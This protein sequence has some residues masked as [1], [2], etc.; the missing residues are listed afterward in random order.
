MANPL[1]DASGW[2]KIIRT[3]SEIFPAKKK[4]SGFRKIVTLSIWD[5]LG[6]ASGEIGK[7]KSG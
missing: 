5:F 1:R 3:F 2:Q 4:K 6:L 7:K